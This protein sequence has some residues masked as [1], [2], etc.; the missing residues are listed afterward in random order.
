MKSLDL[1]SEAKLQE[2]I[3]NSRRAFM[4]DSAFGVGALALGQLLTGCTSPPTKG[5]PQ[6]INR[7]AGDLPMFPGKAKR[8]IYMHMAGGPSHLELFDYK[9]ALEKLDG[10]ECPPSL[11][12]GKRFAF[13]R[14]VPKMLG[15]LGRFKKHGESGALVSH[16]LPHFADVVDDVTIIKSAFTDQFNHAPAQ[17][18]MQTGSAQLGRPSMGS[19]V[20]YGLG[21]ENEDLPGFMVL[22]SGGN[23]PDGGKAM[24]GSGFL[25]S[26]YQ[27]VHCRSEGDPVLFLSNP[28]G[29]SRSLRKASIDAINAVNRESHQ[30]F[31][32][33]EILTRIKQYEMAYRMQIEVP[34]VL[35]IDEEPP[36]IHDLYGSNPNTSSFANNVLLARKMVENGVRFVQLYDWGWDAHGTNADSSLDRGFADKCASIDRPIAA[37]LKDLKQRGL[38]DETLVVWSGEFGRTPMQEN[39]N[40]VDLPFKGRD[41][42]PYAFTMWMAGGGMKKGFTFGETDEIG[43]YPIR[44]KVSVYDIQ[45]TILHQLGFDHEKFTFPFQGRDFRLT[46]VEGH[47]VKDVLA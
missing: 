31:Q 4:K 1:V 21:S 33:P 41:H 10:Q 39:R 40:G 46:D 45:A 18:L 44:D 24:W 13:I 42:H 26:V 14:G 30:H 5:V 23:N 28:K 9:P 36:Y 43:Y 17:L 35:S 7:L 19:W 22:T 47:V 2:A 3:L 38:L 16:F 37:L 12:E 6:S 20:T 25:P 15:P 27:G 32:D 29:M 11:L 34:G 8:I